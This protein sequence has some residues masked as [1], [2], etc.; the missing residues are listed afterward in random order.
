MVDVGNKGV[1]KREGA[2]HTTD[3]GNHVHPEAGLQRCRL[4]QVVEH[5][6]RVGITFEGDDKPRVV[7]RGFVV[8]VGDTVKFAIIDQ[9]RNLSSDRASRDL[10]RERG[11]NEGLTL[12]ALFDLDRRTHFHRAP[13]GVIRRLDTDAAKDLTAGGEVGSLDELHEIVGRGLGMCKQMGDGCAHLVEVVRRD[14]GGHADGN[15]LAPVN[16]Q[17]REASG[18]D[19][20][21]GEVTR[22]VVAE[23][24]GVLVD[25][26][27]HL[28]G[29]AVK[30]G[31]GVSGCGRWVF[32]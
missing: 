29:Q 32:G 14:I 5:Y 15:A 18:K 23:I 1:P 4:P 10:V 26:G 7:T 21:L 31:L 22:V 17:V 8:D 11:D 25:I 9:L 28:H 13:A 30:S 19:H 16:Q 24:D 6:L 2:G 12:S 20:R 3:E 27:K